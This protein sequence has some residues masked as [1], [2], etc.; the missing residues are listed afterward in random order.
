MRNKKLVPYSV[1]V[2]AKKGEPDAI[3]EI[4]QYYSRVIDFHSRRTIYDEYGNPSSAIDPE[5]RN[6][7]QAKIIKQIIYDFDPCRLPDGE[8]VDD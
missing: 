8:I 2:A 1:I 6:R 3:H 7:I 4:L 5:I